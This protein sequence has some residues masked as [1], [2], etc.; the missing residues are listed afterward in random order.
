[1]TIISTTTANT[2]I[3]RTTT[4]IAIPA[5]TPPDIPNGGGSTEG[6]GLGDAV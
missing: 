5:I 1:M 4:P 6:I 2:I 3:T